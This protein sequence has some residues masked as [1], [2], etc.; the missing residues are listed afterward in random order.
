MTIE[1]YN[2]AFKA[3]RQAGQSDVCLEILSHDPSFSWKIARE[4]LAR[5]PGYEEYAKSR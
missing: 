3:G 1:Q 4:Y 2:E 5:I